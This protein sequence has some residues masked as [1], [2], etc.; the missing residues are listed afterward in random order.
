V[1]LECAQ[2]RQLCLLR[3]FNMWTPAFLSLDLVFAQLQGISSTNPPNQLPL[4]IGA[5]NREREM[6]QYTINSSTN[7][8]NTQNS[9]HV[10]NYLTIA[11]D[12]SQLLAWLSPLEPSL[13]HRD[14][15]E[16]RVDN[17]GEWFLQ[18]AEFER[19]RELSRESEGHKA[20]L[21]CYGN[22]GVGKTFIR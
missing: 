17:V 21:F 4:F 14:V 5:S 8:F 6:S 19:W 2:V 10:Q 16:S 3:C 9:I 1:S 22:P 20:V 7:C 11:D 15:R 13:R 18:T 12:R